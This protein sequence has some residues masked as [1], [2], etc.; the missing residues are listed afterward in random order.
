[1]QLVCIVFDLL[2]VYLFIH[3]YMIEPDNI[4]QVFTLTKDP[5]NVVGDS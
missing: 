3:I 5:R 1:M 2:T 4:S